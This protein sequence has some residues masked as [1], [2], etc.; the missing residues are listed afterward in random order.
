M[1]M[2]QDLQCSITVRSEQAWGRGLCEG[3]GGT[4]NDTTGLWI[5]GGVTGYGR[6]GGLVVTLECYY[7]Y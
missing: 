3:Q 6:P 2:V 4:V 7:Q 1:G 5:Q